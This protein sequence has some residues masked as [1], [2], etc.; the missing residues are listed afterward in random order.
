MSKR[1]PSFVRAAAAVLS[2]AILLLPFVAQT[3][4]A[5]PPPWARA[6]GWRG[7]YA[8]APPT[9]GYYVVRRPNVV[10]VQPV[11]PE[12]FVVRR[13]RFVVAQPVPVWVT[14]T[15]GISAA[16]GIHT[17]GLNLG[18][19][20]TKQHPYYGCSFCGAYFNSYSAW[21]R[22]EQVCPDRPAGRVLCQP[23]DDDELRA[24]QDQAGQAYR[25]DDNGYYD[26]RAPDQGDQDEDTPRD[27]PR[28]GDP[29]Y[30]GDDQGD[31]R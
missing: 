10:V 22:H 11:F 18:F 23:W 17:H 31:D 16:I 14:P 24:C 2:G 5:D 30:R 13:P 8:Y 27:Y 4:S 20:F 29:S 19:A 1:S 28:H 21:A 7:H 6:Y 25:G 26:N 12:A 15:Q 9:R 3:A